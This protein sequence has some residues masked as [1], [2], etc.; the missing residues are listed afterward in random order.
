MSTQYLQ[1]KRSPSS[2]SEKEKSG[3]RHEAATHTRPRASPKNGR[4]KI[5]SYNTAS[6]ERQESGDGGTIVFSPLSPYHY[7]LDERQPLSFVFQFLFL[8]LVTV[9]PPCL[10]IPTWV[11]IWIQAPIAVAPKWWC[12]ATPKIPLPSPTTKSRWS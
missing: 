4:Q 7:S 8:F 9:A 5:G 2:R 6:R 10:C 1:W 12:D 3:G 11:C